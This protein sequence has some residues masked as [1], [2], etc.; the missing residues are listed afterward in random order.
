MNL[1]EETHLLLSP[2]NFLEAEAVYLNHFGLETLDF[3]LKLLN[4][5]LLLNNFLKILLGFHIGQVD[6]RV[7]PTKEVLSIAT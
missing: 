1:K 6:Q 4:V 5:T 3:T 2:S 7:N